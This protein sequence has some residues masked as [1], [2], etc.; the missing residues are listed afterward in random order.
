M[1]ASASG[2]RESTFHT[3]W[4]TGVLVAVT[5]LGLSGVGSSS[6]AHLPAALPPVSPVPAVG[7]LPLSSIPVGGGP[8]SLAVD[9]ATGYLYVVNSNTDNV[10]VINGATNSVLVPSIGVG[11]TP[12]GIAFDSANGDLYVANLSAPYTASHVGEIQVIN[13]ATN[14]V[15]PEPILLPTNPQALAFDGANGYLYATNFWYFGPNVTVINGAT[16]TV[17]AP[18]IP[19][20]SASSGIAF[21]PA[22]GYLYVANYGTNNVTVINAATDRVIVPSIPVGTWPTAVAVDSTNGDIYVANSGSCNVTVIDGAT[23]KVAVASVPAGLTTSGD[24]P[25]AIA[26]DS[27]NGYVYVANPYLNN[28]TVIDG[29]TN[30]VAVASLPVGGGPDAIAFDSSN[31]YV[32]VANAGS[33]DVTPIA[34][35]SHRAAYPVTFSESGLPPGTTWTVNVSGEPSVNSSTGTLAVNLTNGSYTYTAASANGAYA[36]PGGSFTVNGAPTL[37]NVSFR[38]G[39]ALSFTESG[40]PAGTL[41]SV[42]VQFVGTVS[43][44]TTTATFVVSNG[45]YTYGVNGVPGY[46]STPHIATVDVTGV[47]VAVPIVFT[48]IHYQVVFSETGLPPGDAWTVVLNGSVA[49][50]TNATVTFLEPLGNYT[51]LVRGPAN[52]RVGGIPAS[53]TVAVTGF[54]VESPTFEKGRTFS[55]AFHESGLPKGQ[56]WTVSLDG[57]SGTSTSSSLKFSNLT[58]GPYSY[59]VAPLSGQNITAKSG[60]SGVPLSGALDLVSKGLSVSLK[61]VYPYPVTFSETGLPAGTTWA[62]TLQGHR[63]SSTIPAITLN[64]PNGSYGYK[65]GPVAGYTSSGS[66]KKVAVTGAGVTVTVVYTAKKGKSGVPAGLLELPL[67]LAVVP[68]SLRREHASR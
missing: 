11:T 34:P 41:W 23:N 61:Y 2:R 57:W 3:A 44:R 68:A 52:L 35:L 8:F 40:L 53:G 30:K 67:S 26:F 51:Y 20:G 45:T 28:L 58:P 63:T 54:T 7:P 21:D 27:W 39:Y 46:N 33:N 62:V 59:E 9:A 37:V 50:T 15:E 25:T 12:L 5:A 43:S 14:T 13:G 48:L 17:V 29:A 66:P 6:G 16:N 55:I 36:S 19:S 60:G 24:G 64:A 38:Q 32:Y 56:R 22:N 49:G 10:T 65:I 18:A 47:A 42:S 4:L 31:G 1:P